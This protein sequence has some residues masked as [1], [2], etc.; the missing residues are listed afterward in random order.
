M[1]TLK[2]AIQKSGRLS[3]ETFSLL[4]KSGFTFEMTDRRLMA[5]CKNFPLELLFLRPGDIPEIVFDGVADLGICGENSIAEKLDQWDTIEKLNYGHC[6]LSIA[7]PETFTGG[8]NK[9]KIAT[10]YPR[11]LKKHLDKKKLTAEIITLSGSVEIAP[12]LGSADIICDLVSTGSTLKMNGLKEIETI[13]SSEAIVFKCQT[14]SPEK[15]LLL[16]RF[17]QRIRAVLLAQKYKYVVLNLE[18]KNLK[19]LTHILPGLKSPTVSPLNNDDWVSVST[20]VEEKVFWDTIAK[21]KSIGAEG[22]LVQS[23]EKLIN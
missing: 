3:E 11:I 23:I 9:T 14:L 7:T 4:N 5:K 19:K 15:N 20:V 22:I 13:F 18:R 17:L 1:T 21:L 8:I 10:S 12:S 2:I 16:D 6:R